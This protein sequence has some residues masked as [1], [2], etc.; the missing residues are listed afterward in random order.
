[1]VLLPLGDVTLQGMLYSCH[2]GDFLFFSTVSLSHSHLFWSISLIWWRTS[3]I[4]TWER[5]LRQY[6]GWVAPFDKVVMHTLVLRNFC[7]F[8]FVSFFLFIYLIFVE[9]LLVGCGTS[10]VASLKFSSSNVVHLHLL[11][12]F[13]LLSEEHP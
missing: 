13:V 2:P 5:L 10:W 3:L 11:S 9:R 12:L 1:M 7:V 6:W 8:L 4:A